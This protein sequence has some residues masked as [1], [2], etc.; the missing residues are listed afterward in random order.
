MTFKDNS[1]EVKS[2]LNKSIINSLNEIGNVGT[3]ESQL[4]TPVDTGKLRRAQT[5]RTNEKEKHVDVGVTK[6]VDYGQIVHDG[7]SKQRS[8]PFLRDALTQNTN[9]FKMILEKHLKDLR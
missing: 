3:A 5:H 4:R 8:Q 9:K 1:K 6:E 2:K 7:S